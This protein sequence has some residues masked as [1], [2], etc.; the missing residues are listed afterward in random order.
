MKSYY[1]YEHKKDPT[2][3]FNITLFI[4]YTNLFVTI[5]INSNDLYEDDLKKLITEQ[6][7]YITIGEWKINYSYRNNIKYVIFMKYPELIYFSIKFDDIC[8]VFIS[9]YNLIKI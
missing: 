6:Y 7:G 5:I 9:L 8:D 4:E 1:I 3:S 2:E